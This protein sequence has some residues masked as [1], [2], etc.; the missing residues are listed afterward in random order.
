MKRTNLVT[1]E[2]GRYRRVYADSN[3]KLY[4]RYNGFLHRTHREYCIEEA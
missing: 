1:Y 2:Y 3:G 4:F